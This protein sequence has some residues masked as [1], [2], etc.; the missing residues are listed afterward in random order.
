MDPISPP[1][2]PEREGDR[3]HLTITVPGA[4]R[5]KGAGKVGIVAGHGSIFTDPKTRSEM[6]VIRHMAHE[7]MAGRPPYDGAVILRMCAYRPIPTSMSKKKRALA[8][9]GRMFPTTKP[10]YSNYAKMEDALNK[11]VWVD[12]AQVVSAVIHKR[13]SETPRL[14]IEIKSFVG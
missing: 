14:V 9:A 7:A 13:Y 10:D 8:L 4:P 1:T 6:A 5:G 11:L 12:D 3:F 2:Q